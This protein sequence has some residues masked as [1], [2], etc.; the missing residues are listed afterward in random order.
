MGGGGGG[1]V[2]SL[3]VRQVPKREGVCV[4]VGVGC[5][6][7]GWDWGLLMDRGCVGWSM[8]VP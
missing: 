8:C 6:G 2:C 7:V 4:C 3:G 1:W 5:D